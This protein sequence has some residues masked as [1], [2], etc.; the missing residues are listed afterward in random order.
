MK[1]LTILHSRQGK[2]RQAHATSHSPSQFFS[3]YKGTWN[4]MSNDYGNCV[5]PSFSSSSS[6]A[7]TTP[8][9]NLTKFSHKCGHNIA[10]WQVTWSLEDATKWTSVITRDVMKLMSVVHCHHSLKQY[11]CLTV[12]M[13]THSFA[14]QQQWKPLETIVTQ[15]SINQ[16]IQKFIDLQTEMQAPPLQNG[17]YGGKSRGALCTSWSYF[18][19]PL[20]LLLSD[21]CRLG[22]V[23]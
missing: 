1:W 6:H 15:Q 18:S 23:N 7:N 19:F 11:F 22:E 14:E 12:S 9:S 10:K 17:S 13:V 3:S 4:G 2:A 20:L 21:G 5:T 16:K 8:T